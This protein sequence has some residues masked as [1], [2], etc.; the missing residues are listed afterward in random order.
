MHGGQPNLLVTFDQLIYLPNWN[1]LDSIAGKL[2]LYKC[3]LALVST[4]IN[5]KTSYSSFALKTYFHYEAGL[6]IY[7][8]STDEF[9]GIFKFIHYTNI[10]TNSPV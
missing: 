1:T 7:E 5:C 2:R 9:V 10:H 8:S 3:V 6:R 4:A